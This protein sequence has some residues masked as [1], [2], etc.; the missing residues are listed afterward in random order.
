MLFR[1]EEQEE[2]SGQEA[3]EIPLASG[4][5]NLSSGSMKLQA[6]EQQDKEEE[7]TYQEAEEAE[8]EKA[9]EMSLSQSV[10]EIMKE[11]AAVLSLNARLPHAEGWQKKSSEAGIFLPIGQSNVTR[12]PVTLAFT[13]EK[14][15]ALVIGD[16]NSG[17]SALLHTVALQIFANYTPDEVKLAIADFKEGAEF[18]LYGASRLPAV[19]AVVE[20]DDP[21]CAASFLRYYVSELHR[22]QSCKGY[23][24]SAHV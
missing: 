20:N 2:F 6:Q 18:A 19:E 13:E 16:V 9:T 5:E 4:V 3:D 11:K 21:D 1:S 15:Y 10:A 7:E 8:A 23:L 17:K 22:R 12:Q 24:L 14:P